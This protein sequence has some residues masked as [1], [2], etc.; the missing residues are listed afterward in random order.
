MLNLLSDGLNISILSLQ[1]FVMYAFGTVVLGTILFN[2][3]NYIVVGILGMICLTVLIS[4]RTISS[5]VVV[6]STESDPKVQV[7]DTHKK[8]FMEDCL[9]I[10]INSSEECETIFKDF[11]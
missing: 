8:E 7:I 2:Y 3:W 11:Y 5:Q 9:T 10:A 4:P 6:K 1:T